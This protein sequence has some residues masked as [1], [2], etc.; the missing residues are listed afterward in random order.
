MGRDDFLTELARII[1]PERLLTKP[2][3]LVPFESD[4]L[5]AFRKRPLAVVMVESEEEVI[6]TVRL[7][8][9]HEVPF[10][11]RGSGTSLSLLPPGFVWLLSKHSR[12]N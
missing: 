4:A 7:C 1:P 12:N 6:E 3:Q 11:P 8:A 2:A 10:V 5:T 9:R